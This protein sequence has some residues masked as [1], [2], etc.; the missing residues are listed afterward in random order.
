MKN[1]GL[2]FAVFALLVACLNR[3]SAVQVNPTSA[4]LGDSANTASTLVYRDTNGDFSAGI[5]SVTAIVPSN[6]TS[7]RNHTVTLTTTSL[8]ALTPTAT[9]DIYSAV[10]SA[11]LFLKHCTSTG[12]SAGAVAIS[13]KPTESCQ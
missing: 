4:V 7:S 11:G 3:L 13:S 1:K 8:L 2:L 12:T 5:A 10:S 6:T 9:G